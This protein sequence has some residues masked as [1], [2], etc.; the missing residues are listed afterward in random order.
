MV[1]HEDA[2][3]E[4]L[5]EIVYGGSLP[6]GMEEPARRSLAALMEYVRNRDQT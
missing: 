2:T 6:A 1:G 3:P 4:E 5:F